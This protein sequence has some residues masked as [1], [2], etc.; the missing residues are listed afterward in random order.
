MWAQAS[1]ARQLL[2]STRSESQSQTTDVPMTTMGKCTV[3][4]HDLDSTDHTGCVKA[5]RKETEKGAAAISSPP[6]G[7][8]LPSVAAHSQLKRKA[9]EAELDGPLDQAAAAHLGTADG[10]VAAASAAPSK[11][12]RVS[13]RSSTA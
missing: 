2:S 8:P 13:D 12:A 1:R 5:A 6:A 7:E 4:F 11:K 9:Q 3:C 10:N